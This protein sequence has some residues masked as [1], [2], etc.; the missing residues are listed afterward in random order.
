MKKRLLATL[1]L[2][3]IFVLTISAHADSGTIFNPYDDEPIVGMQI[4]VEGG[5]SG[6]AKLS[7]GHPRRPKEISW[8]FD[9]QGKNWD[10]HIGIGGSPQNWTKTYKSGWV[11]KHGDNIRLYPVEDTV[12]WVFGVRYGVIVV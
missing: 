7:K 2:T 9:T 4:E 6:W 3:L 12:W 11:T 8:S 1:M 5:D 10:A